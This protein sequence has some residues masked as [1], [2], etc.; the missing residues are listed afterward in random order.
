VFNRIVLH[1][2]AAPAGEVRVWLGVIGQREPPTLTWRLD[3]CEALAVEMRPL[4]RAWD[5][6]GDDYLGVMTGVYAFRGLPAGRAHCVQVR[7]G[8]T[9]WSDILTTCT[10]PDAI[11]DVPLEVLLVSCF[12]VGTDPTGM[13]GELVAGLRPSPDLTLLVGDQVYL[14]Q[15]LL[16]TWT[17]NPA[18]L[19]QRFEGKYLQNWTAPG[20]QAGFARILHVAP[21][22]SVP[23]DHEYWNNY[24]RPSLTAPIT[25]FKLARKA[26]ATVA[27]RLYDAFQRDTVEQ[28]S[29]VIDIDPLSIFMMDNRTGRTEDFRGTMTEQISNNFDDWADTVIDDREQRQRLRIP[30]LVTGPSIFQ[31]PAGHFSAEVLDSNLSNYEDFPQILAPLKRLVRHGFP[32]LLLTGDVHYGRV[33]TADLKSVRLGR[34]NG[35]MHEVISSPSS[36]VNL[37]LVDQWSDARRLLRRLFRR[38]AIPSA[39]WSQARLPGEDGHLA[40]MSSDFAFQARFPSRPRTQRGDH[41]VRLSF[42]R[43]NIG[44]DLTVTYHAVP[45]ADAEG[46]ELDRQTIPLR[47]SWAP[48]EETTHA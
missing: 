41:V 31:D 45:K 27:A 3:D 18:Q 10:L 37:P 21:S 15:P 24:P 29:Q 6:Y 16:E 34:P 8:A 44:V 38:E 35:S 19:A 7:V 25:R 11:R 39:R 14:D 32:V 4:S 9:E 26:W 36:L 28:R 12:A 2:R 20:G 30:V 46:S 33:I 1:P 48:T 42:R 40:S 43:T 17:G 5:G 23:D 22:A 47:L 13:A